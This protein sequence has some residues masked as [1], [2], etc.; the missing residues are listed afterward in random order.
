MDSIIEQFLHKFGIF[1]AK[2]E[3][4]TNHEKN[5]TFLVYSN[6]I[7]YILKIYKGKEESKRLKQ[8][9][10]LISNLWVM[11]NNIPCYLLSENNNLIENIC[12][13]EVYSAGIYTMKAGTTIETPVAYHLDLLF[14]SLIELLRNLKTIEGKH[15]FEKRTVKELLD[16]SFLKY[17]EHQIVSLDDIYTELSK[18][19]L[20]Y[21]PKYQLLHGDLHYGNILLDDTEI[22]FIDFEDSHIGD[23]LFELSSLFLPPFNKKSLESKI[24]SGLLEYNLLTIEDLP[25][26]NLLVSIKYFTLILNE[27]NITNKK[28][29]YIKKNINSYMHIY[30]RRDEVL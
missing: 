27:K 3:L 30:K 9:V 29:D 18:S 22:I 15:S 14:P 8:E 16:S 1:E 12:E 24:L 11:Q 7:F 23:I 28:I 5:N 19:L 17:K 10:R 20:S 21:N 2:Y 13:N 6:N 4:L 26:I 25:Y